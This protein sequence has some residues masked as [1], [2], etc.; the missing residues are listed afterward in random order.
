MANSWL[1]TELVRELR[2]VPAPDELWSRIHEQRRALRVRAHPWRAWSIVAA[3]VLM[4]LAGLVWRL[5]ATRGPVE[6]G[7]QQPRI[8]QLPRAVQ[9]TQGDCLLCHAQTP[10][11]LVIR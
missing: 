5:G 4:L 3:S 6:M 2:P 10:A 7:R 1:E 9:R 11:L 8:V